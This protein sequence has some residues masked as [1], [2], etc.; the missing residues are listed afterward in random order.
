MCAPAEHAFTKTAGYWLP[1]VM[2]RESDRIMR[3]CIDVSRAI[4][5]DIRVE[6]L[7]SAV[8]RLTTYQRK[9]GLKNDATITGLR[10]RLYFV[11][12]LAVLYVVL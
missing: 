4:V 2:R 3:R 10:R 11:I 5:H 8:A 1:T 9:P 6:M 12:L 7:I